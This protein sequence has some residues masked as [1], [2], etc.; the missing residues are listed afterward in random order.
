MGLIAF[1]ENKTIIGV[2]EVLVYCP[3]C[4]SSQWSDIMVTGRYF[5]IYWIPIFPVGK[6]LN[7][8]CRKCGLKRYGLSF[9]P[10]TISNYGEIK[11]KFRYRWFH[12]LGISGIILIAMSI[13]L[14]LL[15]KT[16]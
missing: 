7:I 11:S 4:E 13:L 8:I 2:E 5:H 1:G 15:F 6:D 3:S 10:E 12:Y 16:S 14:V 9:K